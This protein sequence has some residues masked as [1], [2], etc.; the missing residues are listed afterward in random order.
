LAETAFGEIMKKAL[1]TG[2]GGQCGSYLAEFLLNK[3][4][5]VHGLIRR[6][7]NLNTGRI[8]H[9][10]SKLHLHYGD[11]TDSGSLNNIVREVEPEEIFNLAAQSHVRVSFENPT[12][13][14][15]VDA[16]G[17]LNLL[18][19]A[20]NNGNPRF[21][22][23]STSELFGSSNP[24]QNEETP[25]YPRSI[26]AISKLF[27]YWSVVNYRESYNMFAC[28][29]IL[30]NNESP[31]RG[32]EFVTKKIVKALVRIKKRLQDKLLLGNLDA[33]RDWG[34]S[35][36]FIEAMWLMLQ[37]NEPSDYVIATGESHTIREFLNEVSSL[38]DLDWTEHVE[39][40]PTLFRPAEV[41][42]LL[43]NAD[44]ARK[45]LGWEPKVRFKDLVK[46]MVEH[47]LNR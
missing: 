4:Y 16:I 2:I 24:P 8:D 1:I 25:F 11:M 33:K 9:I 40:D 37:Q 15:N 38:L 10:L 17:T 23:A 32:D 20:R 22:Q 46:L 41:D 31:R 18:E 44:K 5:E 19:A 14:A 3:N 29:G 43:G 26:Y 42:Y 34:Y 21:Y 30:F 7:S 36:E 6:S 12:Y 45:V 47:E 13:T 35:K 28:N 27:A 39:I